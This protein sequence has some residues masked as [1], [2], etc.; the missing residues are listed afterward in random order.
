MS[1]KNIHIRVVLGGI[2]SG[3]SDSGLR[4][5]MGA[6]YEVVIQV[7]RPFGGEGG[8]LPTAK[9]CGLIPILIHLRIFLRSWGRYAT[10]RWCP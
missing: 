8:T 5:E 2:F 9:M 3:H 1:A 6:R 4:I 7:K 10:L